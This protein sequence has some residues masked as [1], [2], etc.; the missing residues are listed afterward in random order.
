[1]VSLNAGNQYERWMINMDAG[2]SVGMLDGQSDY[3]MVCIVSRNAGWSFSRSA[4]EGCGLCA[5]TNREY[6]IVAD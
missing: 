3:W 6:V 2:C 1:M 4:D 5:S